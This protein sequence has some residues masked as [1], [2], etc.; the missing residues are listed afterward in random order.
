M[1]TYSPRAAKIPPLSALPYPFSATFTTRAPSACATATEPSV[2][3]LSATMTSPR[4]P[5]SLRAVFALRTHTPTVSCSL[6]QGM[7]TDSSITCPVVASAATVDSRALLAG[8]SWL[9]FIVK[10]PPTGNV[11]DTR[12]LKIISG[13]VSPLYNSPK[14][15]SFHPAVPRW[16]CGRE[17]N[18]LRKG[19]GRSTSSV[20]KLKGALSVALEAI[21]GEQTAL[22]HRHNV[23]GSINGNEIRL[24]QI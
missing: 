17:H 24:F 7:T 4:M 15:R 18:P 12:S 8:I 20:L 9:R 19:H 10:H 22:P 2:E 14:P 13:R 21:L 11:G 16:I 6:R 1:S 23:K 5:A 3:P